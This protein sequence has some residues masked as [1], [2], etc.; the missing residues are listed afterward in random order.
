ML[1]KNEMVLLA[2]LAV[3][4]LIIVS[5]TIFEKKE[6]FSFGAIFKKIK[7]VASNVF[8]K[9]KDVG[10]SVIHKV[11]DIGGGIVHK[12]GD[13]GGNVIH[14]VKDVGDNVVHKVKDSSRSASGGSYG[15]K[16]VGKSNGRCPPGT[17]EITAGGHKG[18]C[19]RGGSSGRHSS[20]RESSRPSRDW[21]TG[22]KFVGKSNGRCPPGTSEITAGG[23]KGRCIKNAAK[24]NIEYNKKH[25]GSIYKG[26]ESA[27]CPKGMTLIKSGDRKGMCIDE[28]KVIERKYP[29]WGWGQHEGLRCVKGDNTGCNTKWSGGKLVEA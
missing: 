22:S 15:S 28:Q 4:L 2:A 20:S 9:V 21:N 7:N 19:Y 12:V 6:N 18:Q 10:G 8:N 24:E 26:R 17:S 25:I 23:R 5:L 14:K 29:H 13:V 16:F 1:T 27:S 3:V 11:K